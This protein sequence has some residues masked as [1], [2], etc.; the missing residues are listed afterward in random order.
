M[1]EDH[2]L[3]TRDVYRY[4][5]H[6]MYLA[7]LLYALGLALVVPNWVAGPSYLVA[8]TLLVAFRVGPEE[9]TMLEAFGNDYE[10]YRRRTRCLIPGLW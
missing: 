7:L 1:R 4:V 6:P 5:R 3:V 9:R 2:Q 10:A 8:V